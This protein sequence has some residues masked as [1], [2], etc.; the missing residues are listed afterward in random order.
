MKK[1]SSRPS[2]APRN[3][4]GARPARLAMRATVKTGLSMMREE[5]SRV[6]SGFLVNAAREAGLDPA[7]YVPDL[8]TMEWVLRPPA[9]TA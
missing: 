4:A 5:F 2:R 7:L 9:P 8:N 1:S 3:P 6:Q